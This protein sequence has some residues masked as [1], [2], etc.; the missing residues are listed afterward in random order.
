MTCGPSSRVT[1]ICN[2]PLDDV[3]KEISGHLFRRKLDDYILGKL[4]VTSA[5]LEMN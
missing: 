1:K 3:G 5:A 2:D 4:Y